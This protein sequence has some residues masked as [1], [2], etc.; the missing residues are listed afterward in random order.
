MRSFTKIAGRLFGMM[1]VAMA[2]V[3]IKTNTVKAYNPNGQI[4]AG[5]YVDGQSLEGLTPAEAQAKVE[6]IVASHLQAEITLVYDA[7]NSLTVTAEDMQLTWSNEDVLAGIE[8]YGTK[9]NV[10]T[11]F[12]A[13]QDLLDENKN[14]A[15][16]YDFDE[17]M[18]Q[19][20]L[21]E[22][23]KAFDTEKVE[24]FLT[25]ENGEFVIT[26][27]TD[28]K[29]LNV[30]D[31]YA[32]LLKFIH[33]EWQGG[34]AEYAL[35]VDVDAL[36]WNADMLA[37]VQDL[38]GTYTTSYK[39]SGASRSGNI[40]NAARKCSGKTVY[41]GEEYST[42][43]LM[44][45]FTVAN[46][47]KE[48]HAYSGGRV[49]DSVGG[50]ICQVSSTLYN[51]VLLAELEVTCRKNHAM[52][53]DYVPLSCDATISADSNIDFTWVN[54]T[55]YPVYVEMITTDKKQITVNIY[56]KET[57]PENRTIS[58]EPVVLEKNHAEGEKIY[59]DASEPAGYLSVT[60]PYTGYK[61]ELWKVVCID[62]VETERILVNESKYKATPRTATVGTATGNPVIANELAA[63]IGF[64]SID[65]LRVVVGRIK[66][67]EFNLPAPVPQ[68]Q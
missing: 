52:T 50:G 48:A 21:E 41:P 20:V 54:N 61:T 16:T 62:G 28:G 1:A 58:Y 35:I 6:E 27:G 63:A 36:E 4:P 18:L 68:E 26:G 2:F 14:L 32:G 59:A 23:C 55:D 22:Q 56:G 12:M 60:S 19:T 25:R 66:N 51:A 39:T 46:G 31:S 30:E 40:V 10:V 5:I 13:K 33:E 34:N 67:G 65:N 7:K 53:V 8:N 24:G 45:P 9:G 17:A 42:K 3:L 44:V 57:R 11:R 37:E 15:I 64:G 29:V 38:L 49:I 43:T 47:Y